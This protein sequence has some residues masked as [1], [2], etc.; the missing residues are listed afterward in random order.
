MKVLIDS[1]IKIYNEERP[2]FS[3]FLLTPQQMHRQAKIK[4]S[5]YKKQKT[6]YQNDLVL[7]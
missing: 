3:N 7:S 1:S 5:T 6:E 4:L 2:H